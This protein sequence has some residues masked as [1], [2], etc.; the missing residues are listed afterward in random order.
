[1]KPDYK[2][3]YFHMA[4]RMATTVELLETTV[5]ILKR[6]CEATS[7]LEA[8]AE[9]L[10]QSQLSMEEMFISAEEEDEE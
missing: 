10:K 3:M 5:Q 7:E 2:A 8:L 1:M 6:V 4:G 9:K